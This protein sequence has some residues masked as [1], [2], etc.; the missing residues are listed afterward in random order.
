VSDGSTAYQPFAPRPRA[1]LGTRTIAGFRLRVH[2][3]AFAG[4][5]LD[6][7]RF[8]GAWPLVA[9]ALPPPG[10]P[11][12]GRPGVGFVVLH[13]GRGAD[14][15]VLAWWDREN[16]L[17]TRVF[18]RGDGVWRAAQGGESFCVW[19]LEIMKEERD[20]YVAHVLAPAGGGVEGYLSAGP[21]AT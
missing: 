9:A 17:P 3:V 18:V 15:G 6:E 2:A 4:L 7:A 21:A 5:P 13:A 10:S 12:E 8:D 19:D 14:Y 11:V 20:R 1:F 16:E